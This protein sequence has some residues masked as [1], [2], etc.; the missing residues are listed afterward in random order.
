[1]PTLSAG[2]SSHV[3][4]GTTNLAICI[5]VDRTDG[6]SFFFTGLDTNITFATNVYKAATAVNRTQ[7]AKDSTF[8]VDN[9]DI[10][11][12]LDSN[13]ITEDDL[14]RGIFDNAEIRVFEV[15]Y[16]DP[17]GLADIKHM[18]GKFG[19]VVLTQK[20]IFRTEI[21]S[22]FQPMV[23]NIVQSRQ[24]ACRSDFGDPDRCGFPVWPAEVVV[25]TAYVVGE[26][27]LVRDPIFNGQ[28]PRSVTFYQD[29]AFECVTA[30]TT[31]GT[32][33]L[34]D[35][36][37]GNDTT[38]GTAVFR[39]RQFRT[40]AVT[41]SE[42]IDR[43]TFKVT[44]LT[45]NTT[46]PDDEFSGG[47][48]FF[49]SGLNDQKTMEVKQYQADDGVTIEQIIEMYMPLPFDPVVGDTAR[50]YPGCFKRRQEDC[51]DKFD[52]GVNFDGDPDIPGSDFLTRIPDSPQ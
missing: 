28:S 43:V 3:A 37:I 39:A 18:R 46:F 38:D 32:T 16:L 7:I 24:P 26:H 20:G 47:Q 44:E 34:Y 50:I 2:M 15:N 9:V 10:T 45:P 1:M 11:G 13:E 49:E 42:V 27:V 31:A 52:W 41:I 12:I 29:R 36:T 17:D 8:A 33:P 23:Q 30:G 5:R 6:Q 14:R 48:I 25:S 4:D 35:L 40:K 22:M 51:V 21:R 19:E